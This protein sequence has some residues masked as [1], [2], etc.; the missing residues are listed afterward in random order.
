[1]N[2]S[3]R[4][5]EFGMTGAFFLLSQLGMIV[6]LDSERAFLGAIEAWASVLNVY[7]ASL[8]TM[9]QV[10]TTSLFTVVGVISIFVTGLI[11]D[12]AGSYFVFLEMVLFSRHLNR[13]QVWLNELAAQCQ[14]NVQEDYRRLRDDF[15]TG[16]LVGPRMVRARVQMNQPYKNIQAF[17]FSYIHCF[18]SMSEMLVDSIHLWRTSRAISTTLLIISVEVAFSPGKS[19]QVLLVFAGL[20]SLSA[21]ITLRSYSR[22]CFSLFSLACVTQQKRPR[23]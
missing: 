3:P 5:A 15:G 21:L 14:Q 11:L 4:F 6:L 12:L 17:L 10:T 22:L 18:S 7:Q 2:I 20:F 19:H 8:P 9:L 16:F 1:M 23:S 13:N